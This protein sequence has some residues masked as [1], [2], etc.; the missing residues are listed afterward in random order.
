M[1]DTPISNLDIKFK[2]ITNLAVKPTTPDL[3]ELKPLIWSFSPEIIFFFE[4]FGRSEAL[5]A[6]ISWPGDDSQ[7][8][9]H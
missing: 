9:M 6:G 5:L 1:P 8:M 4:H 2:T 7:K 3:L